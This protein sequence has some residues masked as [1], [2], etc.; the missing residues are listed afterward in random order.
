MAF[1]VRHPLARAGA[2]WAATTEDRFRVVE[3]VESLDSLTAAEPADLTVVGID[4]LGEPPCAA[5]VRALTDVSRVVLLASSDNPATRALAADAGVHRVVEHDAEISQLITAMRQLAAEVRAGRE[6]RYTPPGLRAS[7][8]RREIETMR[9]IGDGLTYRQVARR[10]GLSEATVGTYARRIR[11]K[12]NAATK[13][14]MVINAMEF[15]YVSRPNTP[16]VRW[17]SQQSGEQVGA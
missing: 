4:S 7:L 17:R 10:M 3:S 1:V 16:R 14:E 2:V 11:E 9:H 6:P 12:L 15:G 5:K 13:V 8:S